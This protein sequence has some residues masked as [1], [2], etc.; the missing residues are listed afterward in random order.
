MTRAMLRDLYS[1]VHLARV[2]S[3]I[4]TLFI[5]VP[6]IA[7]LL[8]QG[9]SYVSSW[10]G[11]FVFLFLFAL[12]STIIFAVTQEETLP[13]EKRES[14]NIV[15]LAKVAGRILTHFKVLMLTILTG[16]IFGIK[17]TYL[18]NAQQFFSDYYD[19]V[20][21]FPLFFALLAS[22]IGL[23]F[24]LSARLVVTFGGQRLCAMALNLLV[25]MSL[26]LLVSTWLGEG[27]PYFALFILCFYGIFFSF[28]IL[29]GNVGALAMEYLGDVAG[30][31]S[32]L[33]SAS[34]SLIAFTLATFIG[35]FYGPNFLM[36][37]LS[38]FVLALLGHLTFSMAMKSKCEHH[39]RAV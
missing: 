12:S 9:I 20:G 22:G 38:F 35:Q 8:G 21:T 7:P 27:V 24:F 13:V 18:S 4:Y 2:F 34:S 19:I 15:R 23:A 36:I 6:M 33:F 32:T 1:G 31:G 11:I 39:V 25:V 5:F 28:G 17:L 29:W 3:L 37:A 14:L 26:L 30:L 10:Q 16:L